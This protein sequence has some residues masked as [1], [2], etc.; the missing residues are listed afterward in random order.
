[1]LR[2]QGTYATVGAVQPEG[3]LPEV[4]LRYVRADAAWSDLVVRTDGH[5]PCASID[6]SPVCEGPSLDKRWAELCKNMRTCLTACF[7][8]TLTFGVGA[9]AAQTLTRAAIDANNDGRVDTLSLQMTKGRRYLDKEAWCGNGEKY[10]GSFVFVVDIQGNRVTTSL[11]SLLG[12]DSLWFH[13]GAWDL[14]LADYNQDGQMEL[15]LGQYASCVGWNYWIFTIRP[16]GRVERVSRKFMVGD[17]VAST[18]KLRPVPNGFRAKSYDRMK[19][20]NV[21]ST[22]RWDGAAGQFEYVSTAVVR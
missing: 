12:V 16:S 22:F 18:D 7:L 3:G 9:V 2:A 4:W 20:R 15:N 5:R 21:V 1:M 14:A 19:G 6:L 11:D 10:E 13:T 8:F 17:F